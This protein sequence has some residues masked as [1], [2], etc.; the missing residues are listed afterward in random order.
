MNNNSLDRF[1]V[2]FVAIDPVLWDA[3]QTIQ[4]GHQS[5]DP[6]RVIVEP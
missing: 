4:L 1:G 5:A 6:H 3:P 2:E